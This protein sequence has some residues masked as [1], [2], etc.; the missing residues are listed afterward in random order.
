MV[1]SFDRDVT[2]GCPGGH[3]KCIAMYCIEKRGETAPTYFEISAVRMLN[4]IFYSS[5]RTVRIKLSMLLLAFVR[6][7]QLKL[8]QSYTALCTQSAGISD[9]PRE[10]V[11]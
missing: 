1:I 11:L 3:R 8:L 6:R 7:Q 4:R 5:E 9:S 2:A 10:V